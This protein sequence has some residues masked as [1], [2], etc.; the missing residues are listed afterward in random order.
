[1]TSSSRLLSAVAAFIAL[2]SGMSMARKDSNPSLCIALMNGSSG[3]YSRWSRDRRNRR[4]GRAPFDEMVARPREAFSLPR[5]HFPQRGVGDGEFGEGPAAAGLLDLLHRAAGGLGPGGAILRQHR[6]RATPDQRTSTRR[7]PAVNRASTAL[8]T[9]VRVATRR[10]AVPFP[11]RS[12]TTAGPGRPARTQL[13][14]SSSLLTMMAPIETQRLQ[15]S[16]SEPW[17]RPR[18]ST[19]SHSWP[20]AANHAV[21]RRGRLASMTKRTFPS[22]RGDQDRVVDLLRSIAQTRLD[23]D[24]FQKVV[25]GEDAI[26]LHATSQHVQDIG[27]PQAIVADAGATTALVRIECDAITEVRRHAKAPRKTVITL[28]RA[29]RG[30]NRFSAALRRQGPVPRRREA[31]LLPTPPPFPSRRRWRW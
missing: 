29:D 14:K 13:A 15:I 31:G 27:Y 1:M 22:G 30:E 3:L 23:I 19:W 10:R 7:S 24:Q 11:V 6:V 16:L 12:Q 28:L 20:R 17:P 26:G 21:S 2:S 4:R 9:G 5:R 25:L 8:I 18:S